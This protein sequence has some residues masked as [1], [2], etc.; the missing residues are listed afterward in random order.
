[1]DLLA[2]DSG[3]RFEH[4][5]GKM[6]GIKHHIRQRQAVDMARV[7]PVQIGKGH[8][9]GIDL[10]DISLSFVLKRRGLN[11]GLSPNMRT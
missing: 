4:K 11:D 3:R 10:I 6:R 8:R 1:M 9:T 5:I 2:T 7:A